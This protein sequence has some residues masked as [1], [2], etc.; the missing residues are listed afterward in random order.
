MDKKVYII[1]IFGNPVT[2]LE[3]HN[4]IISCIK[5]TSDYVITGSWDGTLKVWNNSYQLIRTIDG[6]QYS[7][8]CEVLT[9]EKIVAGSA[10]G[11]LQ[12]F[13]K[14]FDRVF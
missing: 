10:D 7:V 13:N 8:V 12:V 2:I 4:N 3:G 5:E 11:V 14:D 9:N 1:D 6:F